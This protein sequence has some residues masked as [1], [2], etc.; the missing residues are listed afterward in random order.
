ES[1]DVDMSD[2]NSDDDDVP[3]TPPDAEAAR[4]QQPGAKPAPPQVGAKGGPAVPGPGKSTQVSQTRQPV[5]GKPGAAGSGSGPAVPAPGGATSGPGVR[6][7]VTGPMAAKSS[8][9]MKAP[10]AAQGD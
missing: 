2:F 7:P 5:G 9:P 3:S 1:E 4:G 6:V 10:V 8:G